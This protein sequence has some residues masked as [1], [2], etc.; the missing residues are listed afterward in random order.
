M[1]REFQKHTDGLPIP[2]SDIDGKQVDSR[3]SFAALARARHVGRF[4]S[5]DYRRIPSFATASRRKCRWPYKLG[6]KL[7]KRE[8]RGKNISTNPR[9]Q[10]EKRNKAGGISFR[11]NLAVGL[12][13]K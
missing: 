5:R 6:E 4:L 8:L 12:K 1:V 9:R 2:R 13:I 10:K 11:V 3:V 7:G